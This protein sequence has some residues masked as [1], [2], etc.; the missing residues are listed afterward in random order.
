MSR[1]FSFEPAFPTPCN[2]VSRN[3]IIILS[4]R[5]IGIPCILFYDSVFCVSWITFLRLS[6]VTSPT[7]LLSLSFYY[8]LIFSRRVSLVTKRRGTML[9]KMKGNNFLE[10]MQLN[11]PFYAFPNSHLQRSERVLLLCRRKK[12]VKI[13]SCQYLLTRAKKRRIILMDW[14]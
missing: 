14:N 13:I 3:K 11:S 9:G 1:E 12:R 7:L 5:I 10:I 2:F 4:S 6:L 8:D